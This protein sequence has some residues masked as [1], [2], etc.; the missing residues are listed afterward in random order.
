MSTRLP[1]HEVTY[2]VERIGGPSAGM[3]FALDIAQ[4]LEGKNY[5]GTTPVAGTGTIDLSGNVGPIGGIKQKMLG[6]KH[7]RLQGVLGSRC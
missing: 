7:G 6:A 3:I 4:R 2:A 5:A 1:G